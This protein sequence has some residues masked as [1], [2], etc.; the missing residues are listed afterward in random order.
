MSTPDR[1]GALSGAVLRLPL[2]LYFVLLFL[3][4][5]LVR[6]GLLAGAL[7]TLQ[8]VIDVV[9]G[10]LF[11]GVLTALLAHRRRRVGG[12]TQYADLLQAVKT[13]RVPEGADTASWRPTLERDQR[14]LR[15]TRWLGPVIMLV[16]A[17]AGVYLAVGSTGDER[18]LGV[19]FAVVFLAFGVVVL[20]QSRS[21]LAH[22]RSL[23]ADV[24]RS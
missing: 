8:I 6:I 5:T 7:S 14:S 2:P 16:A 13:G 12:A 22:I 17:A 9:G 24:A 10:L 20:L 4:W 21:R 19:V 15:V 23:L 18:L 3:V 1:R 11:A